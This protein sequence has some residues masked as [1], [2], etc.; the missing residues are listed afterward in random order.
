MKRNLMMS[1]VLSCWIGLSFSQ[2]TLQPGDIAIVGYNFKNPD[3][4]S[5]VNF[6][7]LQQGTV[8][9]I[10][11]C[12]WTSSNDFRIGEGYVTYTVPSGGKP[13]GSAIT[14]GLDPG[15]TVTGVSGFFGLST[16]GDQLI[17]YQGSFASPQ[18]IYAMNCNGSGVWQ[19]SAPDN[20]TSALPP[21][22]INGYSAVALRE[23]EDG[24]YN[25][26][27]ISEDK[28][29]MLA[30]ISN[31]NN[32]LGDDDNRYALPPSCFSPPLGEELLSLKAFTKDMHMI[33]ELQTS[34]QTEGDFIIEVSND[35]LHYD[36]ISYLHLDEKNDKTVLEIAVH[37]S[38]TSIRI[39]PEKTRHA[40][41]PFPVENLPGQEDIRV[42]P[43]P[44][45]S[46]VLHSMNLKPDTEYNLQILSSSGQTIEA[47]QGN[48]LW[49][50]SVLD[51]FSQ[52]AIKGM[53]MIV[54]NDRM[55]KYHDKLIIE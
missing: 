4:F 23:K 51:R 52:S 6:V 1:L 24:E 41:G 15:F 8:I 5:F 55:K 43:N 12:G 37:K 16:A 25:C 42:F 2:T 28:D 33:I 45:S 46:G 47:G 29:L 39:I 35:Y 36:S 18:F 27:F 49:I 44:F 38:Y 53:Y 14:F 9:Y 17:V 13:K 20:N 7:D 21:G 10:T 22:L 34:A 19:S 11:D 3:E 26:S 31:L 32:W 48:M 50:D 54:I 40:F 30:S